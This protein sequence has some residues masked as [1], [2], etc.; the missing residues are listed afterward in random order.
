MEIKLFGKYKHKI[1]NHIHKEGSY[2]F[3]GVEYTA[4]KD[5]FYYVENK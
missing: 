5:Y 2:M 3:K 4:D 1:L